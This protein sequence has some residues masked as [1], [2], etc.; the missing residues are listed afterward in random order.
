[1][2]Q[3]LEVSLTTVRS[4][5]LDIKNEQKKSRRKKLI[6][7]V[8]LVPV[9]I[10][11]LALGIQTGSADFSIGDV[12]TTILHRFL[13]DAVASI[14]AT[15]DKIVWE[16]RLSARIDGFT[17]GIGLAGTAAL[18]Q[19]TLKNPLQ[20]PLYLG[21]IRSRFRSDTVIISDG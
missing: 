7:I 6:F 1:M 19:A 13:P 21:Y 14:G 15:A 12:F 16:L 8:S 11:L 3:K 20:N 18:M 9:T 2:E 10:L 4:K 5:S 17:A